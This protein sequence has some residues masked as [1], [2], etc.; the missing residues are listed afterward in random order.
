M[1][2]KVDEMKRLG[3]AAVALDVDNVKTASE[4]GQNL[5]KEVS[6]CKWEVVIVS[7]E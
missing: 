3:I 2:V 4:E 6:Q 5:L 1:S 7:P